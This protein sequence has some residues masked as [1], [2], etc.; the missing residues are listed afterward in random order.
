MDFVV[1]VST[2]IERNGKYLFVRE[3]RQ[4]PMASI[5]YLAD[6]SSLVN[7]LPTEPDGKCG[8]KLVLMLSLKAF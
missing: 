2:L 3:K 4:M 7:L 1:H 8:K 5:I 6:I